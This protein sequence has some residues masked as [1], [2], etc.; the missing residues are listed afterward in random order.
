MFLLKTRLFQIGS[1]MYSFVH[2]DFLKHQRALK[3][4][5][6]AFV[7]DYFIRIM[8]MTMELYDNKLY[9]ALATQAICVSRIH[10]L[11]VLVIIKIQHIDLGLII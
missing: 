11:L 10:S 3:I 8:A 5:K 9:Q 1:Q 2:G 4:V 7:G 6:V